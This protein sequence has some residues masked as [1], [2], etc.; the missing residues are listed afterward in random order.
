MPKRVFN[1]TERMFL[2]RYLVKIKNAEDVIRNKRSGLIDKIL[3]K[4]PIPVTSDQVVTIMDRHTIELTNL[5]NDIK[6]KVQ[7]RREINEMIM[8][9]E[10]DDA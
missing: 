5:D 8:R 6:A 4:A 10:K 3:N 7:L 1:D 2:D 9:K